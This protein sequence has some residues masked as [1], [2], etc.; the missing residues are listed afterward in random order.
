MRLLNTSSLILESFLGDEKPPY[1][2]LSHTWEPEGEFLFDDLMRTPREDYPSRPGYPKVKNTCHR[3]LQDGHQYVWIDTCCID[4][5]SSAELSEAINSMFRWYEDSRICYAFLSDVADGKATFVKSR[6]FSRGWTLQ[7][8][9]APN[10]VNF[11]NASWQDLD[12]R[13]TL[14]DQITT[15]T[16]IDRKILARN[17]RQASYALYDF[18]IAQRMKWASKRHKSRTEDSAYCLMGLFDVNMP[19][20]YGEGNR[21][22]RRLQEVIINESADHSIL[23]FRSLVSS[24]RSSWTFSAVLAPYISYFC[25]D[26]LQEWASNSEP[27]RMQNGNISLVA[28]VAKLETAQEG[29]VHP[30]AP[31]HIAFLDCMFEDDYVSRPAILLK[32]VSSGVYKRCSEGSYPMLL[33]AS[34][35][36]QGQYA[37]ILGRKHPF[38]SK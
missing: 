18:S 3:A 30:C 1:A 19:L 34:S 15:T 14:A 28:H 12:D 36:S 21:A 37:R 11:M 25:E 13:V 32:Q 7:E 23:A 22:F 35:N 33:I 31:S 26:I 5:N 2:I 8:L 20:L 27:Q 24:F 10:Q 6:W 9:I 29:I 16:G 38:P 17:H 4:K